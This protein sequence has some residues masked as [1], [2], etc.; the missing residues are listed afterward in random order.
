VELRL[1]YQRWLEV[2]LPAGAP[3]ASWPV[4]LTD[5]RVFLTLLYRPLGRTKRAP[6]T[7]ILELSAEGEASVWGPGVGYPAPVLFY[8]NSENHLVGLDLTL[9]GKLYACQADGR[10]L[11]RS[12]A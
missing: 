1:I 7:R 9:P 2:E 3:Q 8:A 11:Y 10:H 12:W 4:P 5:G 6:V